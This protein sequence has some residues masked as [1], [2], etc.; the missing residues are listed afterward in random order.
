MSL[1]NINIDHKVLA[2]HFDMTNEAFRQLKERYKQGF[3]SKWE[4][5]VKAYNYDMIMKDSELLYDA[6]ELHTK[7]LG[8]EETLSELREYVNTIKGSL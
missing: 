2:R 6:D 4:M 5:Y 7:L 3:G 8:V 1:K